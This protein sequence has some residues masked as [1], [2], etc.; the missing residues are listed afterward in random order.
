MAAALGYVEDVVDLISKGT[1]DINQ[2]DQ[3]KGYTPLM[4][5]SFMG[6]PH[7]ARILLNR[8]GR[9]SLACDDG[10]TALHYS[11]QQGHFAITKMLV[12]AG[13]DLEA[14]TRGVVG[15]TLLHLAAKDDPVVMASQG[16]H[17]E[18]MSVLIMAGANPNSRGVDGATPLYLGA[19]NGHVEGVKMLLRARAN[20]LLTVS[21]P[22]QGRTLVPLDAAAIK[23][24]SEVVRELVQQCGI[25]GCGG[26][27]K[28]VQALEMA[29]INRYPDIMALLTDAGV[30]DNG[31]ALI[32][33]VRCNSE[34]SVKFLLQRKEGKS[35][36]DQAAYVNCEDKRRL[37]PLLCALGVGSFPSSPRIVR[38]LV[39]AGVDTE[40]AIVT[41]E[42]ET[43][44]ANDTPLDLTNRM[45]RDKKIE[46]HAK[47]LMEKQLVRLD[48]IR[49]L[50]LRVE[51]VHAGSWLWPVDT[52]SILR[53]AEGT[54]R[55]VTVST[56]LRRMLPLLR[57]RAR[58]PR[59]LLA[60]LVR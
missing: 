10:C 25:E 59:V 12:E 17:F 36:G 56:P 6:H 39:N 9:P 55:T 32:S 33:A 46:R 4:R 57:R 54:T 3:K 2:G 51:A 47:E 16:K 14:K 15:H 8:G 5:A 35:T 28:G 24:H 34:Q 26:A 19:E 21:D 13:A 53:T 29:A 58:R 20:P 1:I 27:S 50:L 60:A 44:A 31:E 37:T 7:V 11:A 42:T 45:L 52:P 23:G 43:G 30:V 22:E 49:R 48:G 41:V 38:F 18:V 40:W